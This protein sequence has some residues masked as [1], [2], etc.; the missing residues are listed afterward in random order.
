[1]TRQQGRVEKV[2]AIRTLASLCGTF[3][4]LDLPQ[5]TPYLAQVVKQAAS[6][7]QGLY[8]K[9]PSNAKIDLFKAHS[10]LQQNGYKQQLFSPNLLKQLIPPAAAPERRRTRPQKQGGLWG[11]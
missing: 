4:V 11:Q 9:L 3:T 1:M 7:D 10:W 6:A 5:F 8:Q 2:D